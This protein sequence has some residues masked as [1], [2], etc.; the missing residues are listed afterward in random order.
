VSLEYRGKKG[1]LRYWANKPGMNYNTLRRRYYQGW[2]VDEIFNA[3]LSR[4]FRSDLY[5]RMPDRF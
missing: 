5:E 4:G 1:S 3:P 2:P